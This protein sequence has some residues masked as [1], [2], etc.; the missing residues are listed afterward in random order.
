MKHKQ[1]L[2]WPSVITLI[3]ALISP[4][5]AHSQDLSEQ[6]RSMD[7]ELVHPSFSRN[8]VLGV[9]S[10]VI[11]EEGEFQA[12]LLIQ[13]QKAPLRLV[14]RQ[15][16]LGS[17][18]N[19]RQTAQLGLSY[20]PSRR[21]SAR[22]VLPLYLHWGGQVEEW[23]GDGAGMGD[24]QVG[25]RFMFGTWK[26][27]TLGMHGDLFLPF[28]KRDAYMGEPLPR[29]WFGLLAS[30]ETGPIQVQT[31]IGPALRSAVDNSN[32]D[33]VLG[34]ELVWNTAVKVRLP[35]EQFSIMGSV[36]V[37]GGFN[38]F[39]TGPAE[40]SMEWLA[41]LQY[42]P[43]K[44]IQIDAGIGRGIT[45]GYGTSGV[46]LMTG[47]SFYF[48]ARKQE[49]E[50]PEFDV[51]ISD[52]P[53][54]EPMIEVSDPIIDEPEGP[55]PW[56]EGQLA[57]LEQ[58]RIVIR[59][60][61]QFEFN[62]A[63]ILPESLPTLEAVADLLNQNGSIGHLL[64]EGHASEEGTFQYNY[65]LSIRRAKAIFEQLIVNGTHPSRMS[66]RGMGEVVPTQ[67]GANEASLASNRR[68]EFKIIRQF[69]PDE[70][71]PDLDSNILLPWDGSN[72]KVKEPN[73]QKRK[74]GARIR[75]KPA[76]K[77]AAPDGAETP[78]EPPSGEPS[79]EE[80]NK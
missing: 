3:G 16:V 22:A 40:N 30:F 79:N 38:R 25:V 58:E 26:G 65:D 51:A 36:L 41:G 76:D 11:H 6:D 2:G 35:K 34:N 73:S 20:A 46:R 10:P 33:F 27:F 59:D 8:A 74:K 9:D 23:N 24:M 5:M 61:I 70:R 47:V 64:I 80:E 49:M 71:R 15:E 43:V 53:D 72:A 69:L 48:L 66:Y 37:R 1:T 13:Y 75:K 50:E 54:D 17:I 32:Q 12:G 78:T 31:D 67:E 63:N 56:E 39:F 18:V 29:T 42:R 14:E 28:S 60:P 44:A 45:Q 62:T 52:I 77:T 57:R 19:H 7:I 68:V 21:F 4:G 55:R